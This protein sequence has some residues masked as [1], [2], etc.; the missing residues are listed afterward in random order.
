M[1]KG[2]Q[3]VLQLKRLEMLY[4]VVY[5]IVI[6]RLFMLLPRP[7][8][9]NFELT[10][11]VALFSE[12]KLNF[13]VV[14][15]GLAI[16][17]IYWI[18]SNTLF[19]NL[20]KTDTRHTVIAIL[21]MFFTLFTLYAIGLGVHYGGSD[22]T[23][24]L[25]SLAALLLGATSF[26]GWRY[27]MGKGNLILSSVSPEQAQIISTRNLSEPL[28][29]AITIPFAFI[30]PGLWEPSW[31]FYPLIVYIMRRWRMPSPA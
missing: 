14:L 13:I 25:E 12:H 7:A 24:L 20:E 30:G 6:W 27:A 9:A 1:K 10:T 3:T 19:G 8:D 31:F 5:G 22:S 29:A 4:D 15:L 2:S 21:Q 28:T 26:L 18:Q 11:L 16:V 17:I 23:R